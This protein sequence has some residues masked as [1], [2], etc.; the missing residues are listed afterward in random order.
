MFQIRLFASLIVLLLTTSLLAQTGYYRY[1]SQQ[2][3][4][5]VFASEGD[6]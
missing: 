6:L 4:N 1:P 2:G 5:L 3:D